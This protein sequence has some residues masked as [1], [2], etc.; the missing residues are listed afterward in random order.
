MISARIPSFAHRLSYALP[1]WYLDMLGRTPSK[2]GLLAAWFVPRAIFYVIFPYAI[3]PS[4]YFIC[5]RGTR[6]FP[7]TPWTNCLRLST[8]VLGRSLWSSYGA[9][10]QVSNALITEVSLRYMHS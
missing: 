5:L 6:P 7:L 9:A 2:S 1:R 8:I 10:R 3:V 4:R